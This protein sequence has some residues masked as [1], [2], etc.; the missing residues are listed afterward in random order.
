M[1]YVNESGSANTRLRLSS[2]VCRFTVCPLNNTDCEAIGQRRVTIQQSAYS[3]S[4]LAI[5]GKPTKATSS[6]L[7]AI[8]MGRK[9]KLVLVNKRNILASRSVSIL[10]I[11]VCFLIIA[12][13]RC[14]QA[15]GTNGK[16]W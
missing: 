4:T 7:E 8:D 16:Y 2:T 13:S 3:K 5:R 1:G 9:S 15:G 14:D 10:F 11:V 6:E 12:N